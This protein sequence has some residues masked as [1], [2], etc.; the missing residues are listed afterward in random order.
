MIGRVFFYFITQIVNYKVFKDYQITDGYIFFC[1]LLLTISLHHIN[2]DFI[3]F[4]IVDFKRKLY[5]QKV[6][7]KIIYTERNLNQ[8]DCMNNVPLI[9]ILQPNNF[10]SWMDLRRATLDLGKKYTKRVFLYSSMFILFYGSLALFF[11]LTFFGI[12]EFEI[13]LPVI[14]LGHY[15]I[16]A[17]CGIMVYI[18]KKGADVNSY[19]PRHKETLL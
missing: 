18:V 11:T 4:G 10:K 5:F 9:D 17:I 7:D 16:I 2:L 8:S 3:S 6:L 12:L 1:L 13:S 19:F 15:D 14:L